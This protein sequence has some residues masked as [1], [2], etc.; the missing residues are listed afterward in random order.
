MPIIAF[1][2]GTLLLNLRDA[3][4]KLHS[5]PV[6][7]KSAYAALRF[8]LGQ[9]AFATCHVY[10]CTSWYKNPGLSAFVSESSGRAAGI[11]TT[12]VLETKEFAPWPSK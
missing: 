6:Q 5:K 10:N 12:T 11:E 3:V 2:R 4:L 8:G 9:Y 1:I 7:A